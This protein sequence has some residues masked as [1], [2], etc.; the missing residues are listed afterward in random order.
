MLKFEASVDWDTDDL[1]LNCHL[2][3]VDA[4][5]PPPAREEIV[6]DDFMD[7][8]LKLGEALEAKGALDEGFELTLTVDAKPHTDEA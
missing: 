8:L 3:Q 1:Q 7:M 6:G 5:P 4:P 2:V